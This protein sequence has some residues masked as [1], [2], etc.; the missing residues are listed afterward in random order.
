MLPFY[1]G[2]SFYFLIKKNSR[3]KLSTDI[4]F[5]NII[6]V[7]VIRAL[8]YGGRICWLKMITLRIKNN[9]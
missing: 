7:R 1:F 3:K 5:W 4:F 9:K 8:E 6:T 2:F